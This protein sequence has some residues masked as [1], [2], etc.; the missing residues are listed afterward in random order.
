MK[1]LIGT[2]NEDRFIKMKAL[3]T[4]F[5]ANID[6]LKTK[7][8]PPSETGKTGI[9]NAII[10]SSYYFKIR[11][12]PTLAFDNE[13]YFDHWPE[14]SQPGRQ[15]HSFNKKLGR[16]EDIYNFWKNKIISGVTSGH[17]LK[18][19]ALTTG[20]GTFSSTVSVPFKL[21]LTQSK[22]SIPENNILNIFMVPVGFSHSFVELSD[23]DRDK[24]DDKYFKTVI[25]S[26]LD[27]L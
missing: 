25:R 3:I 13:I 26:I 23:K 9:E 17:L 10:K 19:F 4:K 1:L 24:Y 6:I 2:S 14:D 18:H 22:E 5:D 20:K 21:A 12:I 11:R 27:Q 7:S 8:K 15:I 16:K